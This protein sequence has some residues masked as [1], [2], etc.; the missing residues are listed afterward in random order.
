V[1]LGVACQTGGRP[2]RPPMVLTVKCVAPCRVNVP[3]QMD[4]TP[5]SGRRMFH[6]V[7]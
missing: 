3:N 2:Y 5:F 7:A 4:T 1:P 6:R